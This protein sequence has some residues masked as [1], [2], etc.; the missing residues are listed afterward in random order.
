MTDPMK[1][2]IISL[3]SFTNTV[4]QDIHTQVHYNINVHKM[5]IIPALTYYSRINETNSYRPYYPYI[6]HLA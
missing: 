3:F 2:I 6:L 1:L 5:L 4:Q